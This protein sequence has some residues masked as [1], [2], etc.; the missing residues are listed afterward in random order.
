RQRGATREY[1]ELLAGSAPKTDL[2]DGVE[3]TWARVPQGAPI[4]ALVQKI[5]EDFNPLKPEAS[6]PALIDMRNALLKFPQSFWTLEKLREVEDLIIACAGIWVEVSSPRPI[7]AQG[8]SVELKTELIVRRPG[9]EVAL[10]GV[11]FL[12]T[13][14]ETGIYK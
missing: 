12:S 10:D 3:T 5:A 9:V 2:F 8:E 6:V 1:F 7:V 13:Y 14:L 11:S 4:A